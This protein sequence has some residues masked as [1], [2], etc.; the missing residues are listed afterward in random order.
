MSKWVSIVTLVIGGVIVAD[1]IIHAS[2]TATVARA[3]QG[4]E[5][6]A[7]NALLGK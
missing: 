5:N 6:S 2:Q 4:I 1:L 3:G 7:F